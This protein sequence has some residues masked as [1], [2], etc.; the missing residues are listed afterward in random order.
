MTRPRPAAKPAGPCPRCGGSG[1]VIDDENTARHCDCGAAG[2]RLRAQRLALANLPP[3][4]ATKGFR[5][6]EAAGEYRSILGTAQAYA[7][8]FGSDTREG[9][10]LRGGTGSGKTHLSVAILVRVIE[11]GYTGYFCNFPTL[12]ENLRSSYNNDGQ[13]TTAEL[14]EP[15]LTRD[16]V[17][18][19]DLGAET[20]TAW[21]LEKLYLIV[22]Q[23]YEDAKPLIVT[24]NHTEGDLQ[25]RLGPRTMSRLYEMCGMEFPPFPARDWRIAKMR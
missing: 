10:I 9:M 7:E 21:V 3:R 17:V 19:D 18:I 20:P 4:F 14:L 16:L 12:L 5:D 1:F 22:N 23:R 8:G 13:M 6:F 11:R 2:E 25:K 15:V 24:T